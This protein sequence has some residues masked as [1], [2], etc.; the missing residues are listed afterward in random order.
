MLRNRLGYIAVFRIKKDKYDEIATD[1]ERLIYKC[2][3]QGNC[4]NIFE[5]RNG[6]N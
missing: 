2:R 3:S 5:I 4:L 6:D 1:I